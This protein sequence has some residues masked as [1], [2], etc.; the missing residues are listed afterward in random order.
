MR[1]FQGSGFSLM[2]PQTCYDASAYA[3]ALPEHNGFSPNV[4]I[5]FEAVPADTDISRYADKDLAALGA[6]LPGFAL[7]SKAAGKKGQ[8]AAV[9]AALQWGEGPARM[10]QKRLYILVTAQVPRI[11]TLTTSDLAAN[12]EHSN[13]AFEQILRSFTPNQFQVIWGEPD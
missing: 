12:A 9:M 5:G 6:G 2:L 10:L 3:F 13:P 1:K 11:Y 7:T 4:T 8:W